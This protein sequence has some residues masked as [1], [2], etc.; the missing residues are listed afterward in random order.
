MILIS[1]EE[2]GQDSVL[3]S[4]RSHGELMTEFGDLSIKDNGILPKKFFKKSKIEP[5]RLCN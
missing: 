5:L 2:K 4:S 3:I 1:L